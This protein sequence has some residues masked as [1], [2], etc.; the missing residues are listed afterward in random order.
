MKAAEQARALR[1][2]ARELR[3]RE[4]WR[5]RYCPLVDVTWWDVD[6]DLL[7]GAAAT[8]EVLTAALRDL[9]LGIEDSAPHEAYLAATERA[10]ELVERLT[11]RR[12]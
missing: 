1:R 12:L 8:I 10:E 9:L 3:E 4:R 2:I 7:A 6:A 5:D 11:G